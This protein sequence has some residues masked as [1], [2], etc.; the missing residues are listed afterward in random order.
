MAAEVMTVPKIVRTYTG[1]N[2]AAGAHALAQACSCSNAPYYQ[3]ECASR[4]V[5][6]VTRMLEQCC[7]LLPMSQLI[8]V[9]IFTSFK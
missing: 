8:S 6:A 3:S 1:Y 7:E 2:V 5:D 4:P 9:N